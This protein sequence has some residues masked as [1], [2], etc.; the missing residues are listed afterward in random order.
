M[1][2]FHKSLIE[3]HHSIRGFE[4]PQCISNAGKNLSPCDTFDPPFRTFILTR[5]CSRVS[6]CALWATSRHRELIGGDFA[7]L[8]IIEITH[9]KKRT[10]IAFS[11]QI[12]TTVSSNIA[13]KRSQKFVAIVSD[14]IVVNVHYHNETC[15]WVD[16]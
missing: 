14:A 12:D 2:G 8:G 15:Y 11:V 3:P 13:F 5:L 4:G 1:R 9:G 7:C 16:T 10:H 6:E